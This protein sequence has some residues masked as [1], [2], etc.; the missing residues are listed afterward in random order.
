MKERPILFSGEMVRAILGGRKTQTRRVVKPGRL[1]P[2]RLP[3]M[4]AS[5]IQPGYW[6][7]RSYS[8]QAW[9]TDI[10]TSATVIGLPCPYGL[11][12]DRLWVREAWALV[13]VTAYRCSDGVQQTTCPTDSDTAAVYRAG[14]DRCRPG[15]WR[16]SIHMPRWASRITLEVTGVRVERVQDITEA[17]AQAE[18]VSP[19]PRPCRGD[20]FIPM[21]AFLWDR[22]NAGRGAGWA[23]N[24]WVWVVS[25][26]RVQP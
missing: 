5:E 7:L 18:G 15:R 4:G 23:D 3:V 14:W 24:P 10:E 21:F 16:P 20:S 11:P 25:F 8:G 9:A 12:G 1:W 22:L 13:P 19:S 17:D 2:A 6:Q 26:R